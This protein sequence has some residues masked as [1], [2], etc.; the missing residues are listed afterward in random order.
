MGQDALEHQRRRRCPSL[1]GRDELTER[2]CT[3][4]TLLQIRVD[5]S[6]RWP[7]RSAIVA[8]CNQ[9]EQSRKN[10]VA[11]AAGLIDRRE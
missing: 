7:R 9:H 11:L 5:S 10:R 3:I 2:N 8:V 6:L 1:A 4:S